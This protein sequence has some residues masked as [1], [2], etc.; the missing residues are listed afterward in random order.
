[1]HHRFETNVR[2]LSEG[3]Y[4]ATS[5]EAYQVSGEYALQEPRAVTKDNER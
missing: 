5:A 3:L 2:V 1:M 4:A